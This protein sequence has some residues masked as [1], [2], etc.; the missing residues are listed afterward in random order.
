MKKPDNILT[1]DAYRRLLA[2]QEKEERKTRRPSRHQESFTQRACVTW[3]RAKYPDHAAMLFAVPNGG[4]RSR[5]EASIMKGEGVTAGVADL[6]LLEARGC[7]GSLCFEMKTT[8]R[9]SKQRPS[10]KEWQRQ[11]EAHGNRYVVCRTL[12]EFQK[13]AD[14]YMALPV[15][16]GRVT[17]TEEDIRHGIEARKTSSLFTK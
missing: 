3:F 13:E 9:K 17:I 6:I 8:D 7:W 12:E 2:Q 16:L 10:Q 15:P 14:A 5:I 1:V 11:A 4:G